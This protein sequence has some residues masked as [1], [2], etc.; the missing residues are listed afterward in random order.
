MAM[1]SVFAF[2]MAMVGVEGEKASKVS[3]E[4]KE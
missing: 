2:G 1:S 4:R 3:E